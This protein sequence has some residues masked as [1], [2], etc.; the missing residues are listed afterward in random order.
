MINLRLNLNSETN[1]ISW[2]FAVIA[3]LILFV[4]FV[5]GQYPPAV[6]YV[7]LVTEHGLKFEVSLPK[8]KIRRGSDIELDF[9]ISNQSRKSVI[10]LDSLDPVK[11]QIV[12][13]GEIRIFSA[14]QYVDDHYP[15][16]YKF[17][18]VKP[19]RNFRGKIIVPAKLYLE[20]KKYSYEDAAF[21]V[22]FAYIIA[23]KPPIECEQIEWPRPCLYEVAKLK[24]EI[25]VGELRVLIEETE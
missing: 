19:G 17:Q 22:D 2:K 20:D 18:S 15:V 16:R 21:Y 11:M 3:L 6:Q 5:K 4:P 8:S 13:L 25:S 12:D 24:H 7:S 10:F 9:K 14:F 23:K 1:G